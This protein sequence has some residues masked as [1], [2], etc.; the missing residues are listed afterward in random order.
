[1]LT[2]CHTTLSPSINARARYCFRYLTAGTGTPASCP[3]SSPDP[4]DNCAGRARQLCVVLCITHSA[5]FTCSNALCASLTFVAGWP[6]LSRSMAAA[7]PVQLQRKGLGHATLTSRSNVRAPGAASL[8]PQC[9]NRVPVQQAA[10]STAWQRRSPGAVRKGLRT[11]VRSHDNDVRTTTSTATELRW[12]STVAHSS[13]SRHM[14]YAWGPFADQGLQH[15]FTSPPLGPE[16][17]RHTCA[18]CMHT[19]C[20]LA[21][22]LGSSDSTSW[23]TRVVFQAWATPCTA[24]LLHHLQLSMRL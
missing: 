13:S 3:Q 11:V 6:N 4:A 16:V 19:F 8:C 24:F 9:Y 20:S 10:C 1:M 5:A 17:P 2:E 7:G 14:P 15:S 23:H 21:C 22:L 18:V 12:A